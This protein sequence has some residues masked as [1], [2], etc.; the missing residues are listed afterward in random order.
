MDKKQVK[1][2]LCIAQEE[3]AEVTQAIS[4]IFRFGWDSCHP[5]TGISNKDHLEVEIGDLQAMIDILIEKSIISDS[6]VNAARIAKK[7]KLKKWSTI[8]D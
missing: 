5:E 3:C 8:Y 1:E 2:V 6:N 4:K 7:E